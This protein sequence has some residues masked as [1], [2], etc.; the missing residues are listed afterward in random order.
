MEMGNPWHIEVAAY[1]T[2]FYDDLQIP[3]G[4]MEM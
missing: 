4:A 1:I 2:Y 3:H